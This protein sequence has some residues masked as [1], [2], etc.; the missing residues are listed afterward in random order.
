M[1][2]F[3]PGGMSWQRFLLICAGILLLVVGLVVTAGILV[4]GH[5]NRNPAEVEALAR[6]L[7]DFKTF[8]RFKG[9]FSE[10][11][12]GTTVVSLSILDDQAAPSGDL[13]L[14][15][16]PGPSGTEAPPA[17]DRIGMEQG[18]RE[19][20]LPETF[21]LRG[22]ATSAQVSRFTPAGGHGKLFYVFRLKGRS[23]KSLRVSIAGPENDATHE[24]VQGILDTL[25]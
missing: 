23:E 12:L 21:Q 7:L 22:K 6:E 18:S 2:R 5:A 17:E 10:S 1:R 24:W 8:S 11:I 15:T 19:T 20:R 13:L 14:A 3:L 25:K 16:L 4:A 9:Q